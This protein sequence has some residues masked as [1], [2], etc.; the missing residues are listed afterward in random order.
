M[1]SHLNI[2]LMDF[3]RNICPERSPGIDFHSRPENIFGPDN[4]EI[5]SPFFE[6]VPSDHESIVSAVFRLGRYESDSVPI[7]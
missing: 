3:L 4:V 7:T 2:S 1:P 6:S 5:S